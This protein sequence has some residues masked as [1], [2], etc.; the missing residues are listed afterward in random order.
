ML[1]GIN[2]AA[3]SSCTLDVR[4]AKQQ[5]TRSCELVGA[6]SLLAVF[7]LDGPFAYD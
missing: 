7:C 6:Q 5:K 3:T 2:L 4:V 1:D